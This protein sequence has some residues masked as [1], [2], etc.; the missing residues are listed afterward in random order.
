MNRL[1]KFQ[2]SENFPQHNV[3]LLLKIQYLKGPVILFIYLLNFG[4]QIG[5]EMPGVVSVFPN[6]K[7]KLHTTH[8]W[9]FMG[10]VDDNTMGKNMGY[11]TKNQANVIIGFIDTGKQCLYDNFYVAI[12]AFILTYIM[13][14]FLEKS[15]DDI[16]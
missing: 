5:A 9:D 4:V 2:V 8:S 11:S 10:L 7:R 14:L 13:H 16:Y 15:H 3:Q 12:Y 1:T 6:S